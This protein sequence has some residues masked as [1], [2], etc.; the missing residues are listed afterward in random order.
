MIDAN[1]QDLQLI[2]FY[3]PNG[4]A[5]YISIGDYRQLADALFHAGTRSG[6]KYEYVDS[7]NKLHFYVAE[8]IRD[9]V[10]VLSYTVAVRSLDAKPS[11]TSY[12][13]ELGDGEVRGIN[14][15]NPGVACT[16]TLHNSG[17][18]TGSQ[19]ADIFRLN[20][21][22][23][24]GN[25]WR[26]ALPNALTVAKFGE[27]KTINVAVGAD[28]GA[29]SQATIQVTATSESDASASASASCIVKAS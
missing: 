25:G 17:A 10:G 12:K 18:S 23:S 21:T 8:K 7:A 29:D 15:T 22:I 1:P 5:A 13:V 28:A 27:S 16:F 24:S 26:I 3:R 9:A 4:S 6:S 19:V 20:A 11:G 2:N 14:T